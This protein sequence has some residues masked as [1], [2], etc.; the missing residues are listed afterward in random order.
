VEPGAVVAGVVGGVFVVWVASTF[1]FRVAGTWER[2][3]STADRDAGVREGIGDAAADDAAA[4]DEYA[5]HADSVRGVRRRG[6]MIPVT[7][8]ASEM[9]RR[10]A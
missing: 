7:A 9:P 8:T 4:D 5:G 1:V 2:V 10:L 6:W 3:L